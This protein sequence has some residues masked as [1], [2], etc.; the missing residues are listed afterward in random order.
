MSSSEKFLRE[1]HTV[2]P[3]GTSRAFARTGSYARLAARVRPDARVLDL[4]CGD[5]ALL[6][7]LGP[8]AIGIDLTAA[9]LRAVRGERDR[10]ARAR[11]QALPFA[12]HSFDAVTCHLAFMLFD[13]LPAVVRELA[14]VLAPGGDFLALLGGGPTATGDD[15][16]HRFLALLPPR[17]APR[18]GDSRAKSEAGWRE[19]FAGWR[20]APFERW[21][22]DL[23][24]TFEQ[25]WSLL[26]ASYEVPPERES[27]LRA[28][29]RTATKEWGERIPCAAVTYL[30]RATAIQTPSEI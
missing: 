11:A 18:L 3:G 19:L 9:E 24:G 29:L 5:G 28:G 20:V 26:G 21:E 7:E 27:A 4:A 25:V 8:N 2:H 13:D 14:R 16:F 22:L 6:A 23:S 10:I 15:A 12:A 1:F 17:A 30:A